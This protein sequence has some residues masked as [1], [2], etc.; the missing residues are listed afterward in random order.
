MDG[1]LTRS[2]SLLEELFNRYRV[3]SIV[4]IGVLSSGVFV[5][6]GFTCLFTYMRVSN[7]YEAK[8]ERL[9]ARLLMD[10]CEQSARA[11][12]LAGEIQGYQTALL[13]FS[14]RGKRIPLGTFT[15]TAYDPVESCKPFDDG[16]TSKAIPVGMGVAAV[17]PSVIPYGSVLYL[18]E[19]KRYF[20]ASD[21][22][23]AMRKGNGRN[24]D[25]F[26]PTVKEALE[27][28]RR[29]VEVELIDLSVD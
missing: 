16:F 9:Q 22:G 25:L 23:S 15:A 24:I 5:L 10:V 17:D 4:Y 14:R 12:R 29:T 11:M 3:K 19:L 2:F 27:F 28:G 7:D 1:L 6:M 13:T 26:V 21:T 8:I 20:F 18:P